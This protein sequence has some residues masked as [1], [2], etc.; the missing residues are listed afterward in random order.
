MLV[1]GMISGS[2]L[3]GIDLAACDFQ[4]KKKVLTKLIGIL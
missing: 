2:S 3:D 4:F 1:L